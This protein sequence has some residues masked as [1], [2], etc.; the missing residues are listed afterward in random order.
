MKKTITRAT[1][2]RSLTKKIRSLVQDLCSQKEFS[3]FVQDQMRRFDQEMHQVRSTAEIA[4]HEHEVDHVMDRMRIGTLSGQVEE[5][6]V[7][8]EALEERNAFLRIRTEVLVER[9]E[10][11]DID[12]QHMDMQIGNLQEQVRA[13]TL[14]TF[15]LKNQVNPKPS[16]F[17]DEMEDNEQQ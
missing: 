16:Q 9:L 17:T 10:E 15:R 7:K 14:T 2:K 4:I 5:L 3:Q 1:P 8:N 12:M 11:A 13:M 6:T